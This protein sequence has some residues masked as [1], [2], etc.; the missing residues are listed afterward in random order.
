MHAAIFP[1]D[2]AERRRV[3]F[4][5]HLFWIGVPG[6]DDGEL[7]M[8]VQLAFDDSEMFDGLGNP[9]ATGCLALASV[10]SD[11]NRDMQGVHQ[12]SARLQLLLPMRVAPVDIEIE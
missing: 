2:E 9:F 1:C 12:P 3:C 11:G 6:L 7:R 8:V 10:V 4:G 5:D